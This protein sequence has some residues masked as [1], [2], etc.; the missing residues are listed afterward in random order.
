MTLEAYEG[1]LL[2]VN[3]TNALPTE[4]TSIHWH[5]L[6]QQRSPWMD[7]T[8]G[9]TQYA[10]PPR[11]WYLYEIP[12]ARS[13][14]FWYHSHSGTQSADGLFGALVVRKRDDPIDRR[15]GVAA[16]HVVMVNDWYHRPS[17]T[18][19]AELKGKLWARELH[20]PDFESGLINGRNRFPCRLVRVRPSLPLPSPSFFFLFFLLCHHSLRGWVC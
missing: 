6:P 14:T 10:I 16:E 4:V 5:G 19:D 7:G 20:F 8:A 2:H 11:G 18:I 13:G 17:L 1:D 9:I 3:V 12:L 15:Y